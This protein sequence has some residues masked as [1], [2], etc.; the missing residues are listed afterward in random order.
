MDAVSLSFPALLAAAWRLLARHRGWAL[1]LVACS[2]VL[3]LLAPG[4]QL[5]AHLP[6][7][8]E[9]EILVRG[10]ALIPLELYLVP[11]FLLALDA[12]S[13]DHSE[14]PAATWRETFEHRWLRAFGARVLLFLGVG[15]GLIFF[16]LPG[17]ALLAVF[18]WVPLR[19]LLR[20]ETLRQ[21]AFGSARI[22]AKAWPRVVLNVAL[23]GVLY[24]A[25]LL[26]VSGLLGRFAPEP[27][28]WVRLKHPLYWFAY[29]LSG[30]MELLMSV[31]LLR[32]YQV[33]E[34][35]GVPSEP[36]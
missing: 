26:F 3:S 9:V 25:I 14:N 30:G 27:S 20:G 11:R 23:L 36:R 13:L 12:E 6:D 17:L 5:L 2:V 35:S 16:L 8:P 18:G 32:L 31:L 7:T 1:A 4:L 10:T 29:A 33:V 24:L 34:P 21:A 22:M 19:V 28:T 15:L